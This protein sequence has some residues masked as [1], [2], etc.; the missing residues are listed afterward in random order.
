MKKRKKQP[1]HIGKSA[2]SKHGSQVRAARWRSGSYSI[3]SFYKEYKK[4]WSPDDYRS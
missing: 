2:Y 3:Q 1:K 4:Y